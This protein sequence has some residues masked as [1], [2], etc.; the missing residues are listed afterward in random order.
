MTQVVEIFLSETMTLRVIHLW[1]VEGIV[2]D[3]ESFPVTLS[4]QNFVH[5]LLSSSV[6]I[7]H[8]PS[9]ELSQPNLLQEDL[10]IAW[11][12]IVDLLWDLLDSDA[13]IAGS[14]VA[15]R[16]DGVDELSEV[17]ADWEINENILEKADKVLTGEAADTLKSLELS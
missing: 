1:L 15:K 3:L 10:D 4:L 6:A 17:I 7:F 8:D 9:V 14:L 13:L 12:E 16:D 11:R 2:D 5:L